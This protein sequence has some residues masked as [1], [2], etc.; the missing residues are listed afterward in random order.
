MLVADASGMI[1]TQDAQTTVLNTTLAGYVKLSPGALS[2][3]DTILKALG[4]LEGQLGT[5]IDLN[6]VPPVWSDPGLSA[7]TPIQQGDSL[8]EF[9]QK[10]QSQTNLINS[11]FY[12]VKSVT[13]AEG[14]TAAFDSKFYYDQSLFITLSDTITHATIK[15]PDPG[16]ARD[17]QILRIYTPIHDIT[18]P[19]FQFPD[20]SDVPFSNGAA[21]DALAGG[22]C[23]TFIRM[24]NTWVAQSL[25]NALVI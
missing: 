19:V 24:A 7:A 9:F 4:K 13:V 25:Q 10:L 23:Y 21:P 20:G 1:T 8:F 15:W 17:G 3:T 11:L 12:N 2:V 6:Y 18:S 22:T 16:F 14:G 5:K